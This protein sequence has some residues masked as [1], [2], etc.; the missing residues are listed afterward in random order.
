VLAP[1]L[2]F[3]KDLRQEFV[4]Y[5][6]RGRSGKLTS[7][8]WE[9]ASMFRTKDALRIG[10]ADKVVSLFDFLDQLKQI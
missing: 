8:E 4:G 5:I 10:L 7:T 9:D 3:L 2:K 1:E 6:R